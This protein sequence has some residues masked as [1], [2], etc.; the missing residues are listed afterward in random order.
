MN[1][2][3]PSPPRT[4]CLV[5]DDTS[6]LKAVSRLLTSA[7]FVVQAFSEAAPFLAYISANRVDLVVLDIW[8]KQMTGLEVLAHLCSL[9]PRTRIIIITGREDSV[10]KSIATQVGAVG[11]FLKP[12]DDEAFLAAVHHAL[13][14][15]AE[16]GT[17]V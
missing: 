3:E 15:A 10:V 16:H 11:F 6:V 13:G 8:M 12:F 2:L 7:G 1:P 9:S 14:T 4:I 17:K 5:D